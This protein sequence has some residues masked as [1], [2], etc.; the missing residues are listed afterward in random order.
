MGDSFS[1]ACGLGIF[2]IVGDG[3]INPRQNRFYQELMYPRP[4]FFHVRLSLSELSGAL[5]ELF[6]MRCGSNGTT[7]TAHERCLT[8]AM[9]AGSMA[10]KPAMIGSG[11]SR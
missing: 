9:N 4:R 7:C 8:I 2:V 3:V 11:L 5:S 1:K 10:C 6:V